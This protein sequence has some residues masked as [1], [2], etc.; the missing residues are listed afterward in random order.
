MHDKNAPTP[1]LGSAILQFCA[2]DILAHLIQIRSY[3]LRDDLTPLERQG[4]E[5]QHDLLR[6]QANSLL[7]AAR[8]LKQLR[9]MASNKPSG[10]A[11]RLVK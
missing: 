1:L 3:L 9:E 6:K 2:G 7:Q 4:A 5:T 11:L 8:E 10:S